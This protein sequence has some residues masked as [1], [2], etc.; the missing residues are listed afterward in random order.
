M[1]G[2]VAE[3]P[4]YFKRITGDDMWVYEYDATTV[5]NKLKPKNHVI[6][7]MWFSINSFHRAKRPIRIHDNVPSHSSMIV[8]DFLVKHETSV[9]AQPP[10]LPILASCDLFLFSELKNPVRGTR[11]KSTKAIKSHSLKA[12]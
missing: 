6:N 1:L 5:K 10:Y 7:V 9:I 3:S 2:N 12:L 8:I 11:H 4:T